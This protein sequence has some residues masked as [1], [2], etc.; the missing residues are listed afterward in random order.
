MEQVAISE[1]L[2]EIWTNINNTIGSIA[3]N[4]RAA[5]NENNLAQA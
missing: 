3:K 1:D 5:W 2:L 4:L